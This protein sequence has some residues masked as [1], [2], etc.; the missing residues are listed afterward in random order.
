MKHTKNI[1]PEW[2]WTHGLHDAN[3]ISAIK[4]ESDWNPDDDCLILKID[5]EG[6][7]YEADITEIR[8]YN[9]RIHTSNFDIRLLNGG[10]WLTDEI[11]KKN[12]RYLLT[13]EFDTVDCEKHYLKISFQ[14]AE[15]IRK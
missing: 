12:D 6:A 13:L 1:V 7:L 11:E 14:R 4:K 15:V 2:Y 3:I 10:W 8:F 5:C 9:Y